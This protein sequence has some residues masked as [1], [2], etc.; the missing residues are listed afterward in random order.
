MQPAQTTLQ[1]QPLTTL[2]VGGVPEHFNYPWHYA[3][4]IQ[5]FARRG[6]EVR[7]QDFYEGTGAMTRC[8]ADDEL[9]MA[10]LLSEGAVAA[11]SRECPIRILGWYTESPLIWGVHTRAGFWTDLEQVRRPRFAISRYGSGSHLMAHVLASQRG[12]TDYEFVVVDNLDGAVA[13]FA[14]KQAD[15]FLWERFTTQPIVDQGHMVRIGECPT[16]WPGFLVVATERA[17]ARQAAAVWSAFDQVTATCREIRGTPNLPQRIAARFK[18]ERSQVMEWLA[19]T[20]WSGSPVIQPDGLEAIIRRLSELDL[21]GS[22]VSP[23]R[24][25]AQR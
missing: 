22:P 14:R 8:L 19:L 1:T 20:R 15:L 4:E 3:A 23:D 13:A 16:P 21:L 24:C 7:W 17:L 18:L 2:R 6:L 25:L 12:W 9:D 10:V 11:I 5:G